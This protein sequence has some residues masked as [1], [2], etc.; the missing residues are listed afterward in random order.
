MDISSRLRWCTLLT[1]RRTAE[2]HKPLYCRCQ[3]TSAPVY[4]NAIRRVATNCRRKPSTR[5]TADA[6]PMHTVNRICWLHALPTRPSAISNRREPML[7]TADEEVDK[8]RPVEVDP[9]KCRWSLTITAVSCRR[10]MIFSDPDFT[11]QLTDWL[12]TRR[13]SYQPLLWTFRSTVLS[14]PMQLQTNFFSSRCCFNVVDWH[15]FVNP[16]EAW[17]DGCT[18][19]PVLSK[20]N[21]PLAKSLPSITRWFSQKFKSNYL[22]TSRRCLPKLFAQPQTQLFRI[23]YLRHHVITNHRVNNVIMMI[24]RRRHECGR[25]C[26]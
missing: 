19:Q 8:C 24:W 3:P 23:H 12:E 15:T 22:L 20:C 10:W 17:A 25:L 5:R 13:T 4:D 9:L 16:F 14:T 11:K 2:I 26:C 6:V 21:F 7:R 18:I 1:C